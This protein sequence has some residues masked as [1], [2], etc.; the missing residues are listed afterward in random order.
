MHATPRDKTARLMKWATYASVATAVILIVAKLAAWLWTDS[1][2]ILASLID[3]SLD[4]LAS[5]VNL[6]AVRHALRPADREHRFGHGKAESLAGLG[7]SMFIAGSAGFLLLEA[8]G[9]LI[10]PQPVHVI[11][12]GI[13]VMIFSMIATLL[14]MMI[15]RRAIKLSGST[16]IKADY[17]HYSTD[18]IVSISVIAALI[19]T[20]W[21][22]SGFDTLFA[23]A[24]VVYILYSSWGIASEAIQN[25]MDRELP[26]EDRGRI[27]EIVFSQKHVK[28]MHDLRTRRVGMT[29]FIQLHLE[30]DD[31]LTL[32]HAHAISDVVEAGI[33]EAYP[34]SEIII[35]ED[36]A[37]LTEQIPDFD[38]AGR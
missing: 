8:A 36:P 3:S 28:G 30:L 21:G 32:L 2:S 23:I 9:R 25:L 14:L 1:I 18:L 13:S 7:Q 4:A 31:N 15:Q 24:I 11:G 27:H 34:N 37:S 20:S 16:A 12:I 10:R 5:L 38:E 26:D 22:W 29:A 19:L 33:R 6:L 17:L 35:H